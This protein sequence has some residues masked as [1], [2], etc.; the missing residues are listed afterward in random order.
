MTN[1]RVLRVTGSACCWSVQ[2]SSTVHATA[3]CRDKRSGGR[4]ANAVVAAGREHLPGCYRVHSTHPKF[5]GGRVIDQHVVGR[6]VRVS[7]RLNQQLRSQHSTCLPTPLPPSRSNLGYLP[8]DN[9]PST[10]REPAG[11][12]ATKVCDVWPVRRQAYGYLPNRKA[13]PSLD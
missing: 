5:A 2:F 11:G 13:S 12:L 6:L 1:E 9:L 10:G 8:P 7:R 3:N 4:G